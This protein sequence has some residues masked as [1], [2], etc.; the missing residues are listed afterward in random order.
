MN[1]LLAKE[2]NSG[3]IESLPPSTAL[4]VSGGLFILRFARIE[5]RLQIVSICTH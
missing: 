2:L 1:N 3:R 5:N 4:Y